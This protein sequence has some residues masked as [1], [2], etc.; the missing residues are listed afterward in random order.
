LVSQ[1]SKLDAMGRE[2]RLPRSLL[3][4]PFTL[5]DARAKGLD[6]WHLQGSSWRKV[7]PA[8]FVSARTDPTPR[9]QLEAAL[10]RL[11]PGAV[12]SG[13]TAAW[14]HG[15]PVEPCDPIEVIAPLTVGIAA[16]VGMHIR[17]C[18]LGKHDVVNA[19]G[20]PATSIL[21]TVRDLCLRLQL[22][23]AV[24]IADMALHLRRS[25]VATLSQWAGKSSGSQGVRRLRKV[26]EFVEPAAESPMETRLRMLLVLG[27]LPRPEAQVTIRD[28]LRRTVGRLDL[29]YKDQRLGLEYDGG[30]HRE[31]AL[32]A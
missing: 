31:N 28:G 12:F 21:R 26:L 17:R 30:Q 7:G 2:P 5:A 1:I 4:K 6:R 11:P 27:G 16:R 8:T 13:L 29:Y 32:A 23:E 14:L 10:L 22:V 15:L 24:V 20:L 9:L 19:G 3:G 18:E 25:T